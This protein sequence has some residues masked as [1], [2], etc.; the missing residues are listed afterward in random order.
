MLLV[1]KVDTLQHLVRQHALHVRVVGTGLIQA[2]SP[3]C[4]R[5]RVSLVTRVHKCPRHRRN[6]CAPLVK[7]AVQVQV[8]AASVPQVDIATAVRVLC[9]MN[10]VQDFTRRFLGP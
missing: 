9:V 5:D 3:V 6:W 4:A 2:C 8:H 7:L 10:A 1:V